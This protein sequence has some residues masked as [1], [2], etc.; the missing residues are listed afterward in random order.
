MAAASHNRGNTYVL[1][2]Y[3]VVAP[4]S[5]RLDPAPAHAYPARGSFLERLIGRDRS[6]C[7]VGPARDLTERDHTGRRRRCRR[8]TR[9]ARRVGA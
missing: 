7:G 2:R 5:G 1:W 9:R 8:C 6:L 3:R 4:A